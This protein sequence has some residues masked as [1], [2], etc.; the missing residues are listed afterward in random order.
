MNPRF[1]ALALLV[2]MLGFAGMMA[3]VGFMVR[4]PLP[5]I[6]RHQTLDIESC[7]IEPQVSVRLS[8]D[9]GFGVTLAAAYPG[10]D[11]L[12]EL[13]LAPHD[14]APLRLE[15]ESTAEGQA[16]A[17][18]QLTRPGRWEMTIIEGS[19]RESFAFIVQE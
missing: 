2:A 14:G 17:R 19:Q 11:A 13:L 15:W 9:G 8:L 6:A 4:D 5:V 3:S 12:P 10:R 16:Q 7:S 1:L 18:G